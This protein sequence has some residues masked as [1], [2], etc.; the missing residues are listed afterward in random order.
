M[1]TPKEPWGDK[2]VAIPLRGS[3]KSPVPF[4]Q[5]T[6]IFNELNQRHAHANPMRM[7]KIPCR[8]HELPEKHTG[9]AGLLLRRLPILFALFEARGFAGCSWRNRNYSELSGRR[10]N[11]GRQRVGKVYARETRRHV[12]LLN[13]LL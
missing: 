5:M 12:P 2:L 7:R 11:R 4:I 3:R 6:P 8:T 1:W 10:K 13:E 9:P